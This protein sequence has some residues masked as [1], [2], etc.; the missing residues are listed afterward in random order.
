ME[1]I[2]CKNCEWFNIHSKERVDLST[3]ELSA[4]DL[5]WYDGR[6]KPRAKLQRRFCELIND[7]NACPDFKEKKIK[8]RWWQRKNRAVI[9]CYVEIN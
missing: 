9:K 1:Q 4:Y 7:D 6:E 3:C 5:S 8:K 2:Y